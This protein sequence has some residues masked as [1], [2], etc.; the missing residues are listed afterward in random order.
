MAGS[1]TATYTTQ[2][3]A[4]PINRE[5]DNN[6]LCT[7]LDLTQSRRCDCHLIEYEKLPF[8]RTRPEK[9]AEVKASRN[10]CAA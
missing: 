8:K 1:T 2:Y 7:G 10:K 3:E 5:S 9:D 4:A 6:G